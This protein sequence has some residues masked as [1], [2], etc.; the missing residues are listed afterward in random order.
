MQWHE[1]IFSEKKQT[2][3]LRHMCFW[4]SWGLY[5]ILCDFLYRQPGPGSLPTAKTGHVVLG[6]HILL[7]TFLLLSIYAA[8]CYVFIYFLLPT[9]IK[10]KWVKAAGSILLLSIFLFI[11]ARF[12]YWNVFPFI[13]SLFGPSKPNDYFARF[14]P[15]VYLGLLNP[16]KV[17]ASA[18]VIKF[19]KYWWL[20][21][22]ESEILERKKLNV[23]LQLLKAQL[24]PD[25]LFKTLNNVYTHALAGSHRTSE[26]LLKL[27]D[28]LS[29]TLYECDNPLVPLAKEIEMMKQYIELERA[30]NDDKIEM[31]VNVKGDLSGK[32]IA[33][34]L[35]LPFIENSFKYS[36]Q[37][38]E[39]AWINMNIILEGDHFLMKLTNGISE[40]ANEI[41]KSRPN[42]LADVQKRLSLLYPGKYE[43]KM[44]SEQEMFIVFLN[45]KL[46]GNFHNSFEDD[47]RIPV[48]AE[49]AIQT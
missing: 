13:D 28:L 20:K 19:V 43:L 41:L 45:I 26:M 42:G 21:Q 29:Y 31:E 18:G 3:L 16:T 47:V 32:I 22:K 12:M 38:T 40:A 17:V 39:Q 10:R 11:V 35:L 46:D 27:S 48:M 1:F 30:R 36:G 8:P 23:E 25:F 49:A 14:W 4:I 5:L 2:R 6:S 33:P 24:H 9:M 34:F 15:A 44:L 37:V 7:K